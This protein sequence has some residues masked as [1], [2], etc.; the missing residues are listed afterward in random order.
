MEIE[1]KNALSWTE[2]EQ[3]PETAGVYAW[4]SKLALSKADIKKIVSDIKLAKNDN[5]AAE[6]IA[7]IALDKFIFSPYRESPYEVHL[8]G[9]LKPQFFGEVLHEPSKSDG[10]IKRIAQSPEKL[11]LIASVLSRSVPFFTAPLYIGMTGNLRNRLRSHKQKIIELR[12]SVGT[13]EPDGSVESGFANQVVARRFD[14]TGLFV[15]INEI[16]ADDGEQTDVE[17]ILNRIN[18]PIFGRN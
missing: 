10:L 14:H 5:L 3:A 17:H 6:R 8:R 11:E 13:A 1:L 7:R 18:Y 9:L 2:I 16:D 12:E 15:I 4:Y